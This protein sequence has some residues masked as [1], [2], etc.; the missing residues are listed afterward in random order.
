MSPPILPARSRLTLTRVLAAS[1]VLLLTAQA[2]AQGF[3]CSSVHGP[4]LS[5]RACAIAGGTRL[6]SLGPVEADE[7]PPPRLPLPSP[8]RAPDYLGHMSADCAGL[9]DAIR[10]APLRGL[11]EAT[12]GELR[13]DYA[14]RCSADEALARQRF[15][16]DLQR[17]RQRREQQ[18]MLAAQQAERERGEQQR[19]VLQC[20][21][22]R[23]IL[24]GKHARFDTL[25]PGE[26]TDLRHF[27]AIVTERC[28]SLAR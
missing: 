17:Q 19:M 12:R 4:Y 3:R 28:G 15:D 10:T 7:P 24:A 23:R 18:V 8:E 20:G 26:R 11:T 25:S 21:E 5:D 14:R 1:A 6:G 27:E 22:M 13:A 2:G 9:N 16:Q